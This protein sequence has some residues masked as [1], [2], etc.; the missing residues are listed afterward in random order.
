MGGL[1]SAPVS[2]TST[3]TA[4]QQVTANMQS[5]CTANQ[6]VSQVTYCNFTG[7]STCSDMNF[8]CGNTV[9]QANVDC[10]SSQSAKAILASAQASSAVAASG[11]LSGNVN[12]KSANLTQNS[13]TLALDQACN[14]N[15][16]INQRVMSSLQCRAARN[17]F[18]IFNNYSGRTSCALAAVSSALEISSQKSSS[19]ASGGLNLGDILGIAFGIVGAILL[20]VGGIWVFNN[21]RIKTRIVQDVHTS[22]NT[23]PG[24]PNATLPAAPVA[25][26]AK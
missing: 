15:T 11:L 12:S 23:A 22:G 5:N 17:N 8:N 18:N 7:S 3:N 21:V 24:L 10:T 1:F 20:L 13:V 6:K 9:S 19:S 2:A 26:T 16:S 14:V 25:T 4:I